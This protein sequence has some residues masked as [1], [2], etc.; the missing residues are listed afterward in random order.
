VGD[1]TLA[2][3][4]NAPVVDVG[5][6]AASVAV[7]PAEARAVALAIS[8]GAVTVVLTP[9]AGPSRAGDPAT[10]PQRR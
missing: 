10:A 3:A 5:E 7:S 9:G 4:V 1:S 8:R 2:I 6:D